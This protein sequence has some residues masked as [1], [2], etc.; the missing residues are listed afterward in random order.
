[1]YSTTWHTG[2]CFCLEMLVAVYKKMDACCY[3]GSMICSLALHPTM[4]N[5]VY[6]PYRSDTYTFRNQH[7][8]KCVN[9]YLVECK[10][11]TRSQR[12]DRNVH[13]QAVAI[14]TNTQSRCGYFFFLK[15]WTREGGRNPLGGERC[16]RW[17]ETH[18]ML[19]ILSSLYHLQSNLL[20]KWRWQVWRS[21]FTPNSGDTLG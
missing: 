2:R 7:K 10:P 12:V 16:G 1:M 14:I 15:Q 13:K 3:V 18:I 17:G 9:R 11:Q 5:Y 19:E 6:Q 8:F 21:L 20:G 4:S